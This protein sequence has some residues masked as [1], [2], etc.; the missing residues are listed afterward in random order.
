MSDLMYGVIV[1]GLLGL[2]YA[3][4]RT[5]WINR[6]EV[7][8]DKMRSI[9][10]S[11]SEGAMAFLKAEYRVLA[12]FVGVVAVLLAVANMGKVE[13]SA[14]IALS[15]V[16]GA[17]TSGLAGFLGMRVAIRANTRTTH[18]ART[19]LAK[20]L[21]VAFAGGSVMGLNVVGLG[22]LGLGGLLKRR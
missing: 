8:T 3:I 5:A 15:F 22:V 13:S 17:F 12:I 20:A 1:A 18:A 4:W 14:L 19:S 6:Q 7:G 21:H 11:I 10:A 2:I 16:T 9:G